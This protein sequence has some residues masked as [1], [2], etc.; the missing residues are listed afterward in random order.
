MELL[1]IRHAQTTSN[2][3][4]ALDTGHP[5]ADLTELGEQQVAELARTLAPVTL[6][7]VFVSPRLRTRRTAE[8]L[9][10]DRGLDPVVRDGLVEVSAGDWEMSTETE[11]AQAYNATVSSWVRG[12]LEAAIPGGEPGAA[13]LARFDAVVE[14]VLATGLARVAI[15]AHGAVLRL[16]AGAR[17]IG[18]ADLALH[19]PLG[20]TGLVRLTRVDDGWQPTFWDT[21]VVAGGSHDDGPGGDS[22]DGS[23][24]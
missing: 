14:E 11:R 21:E 4:G 8:P 9:L 2:V 22:P 6:D 23:S 20:N 12:D 1:L 18:A 17:G 5:G 10:R 19:R 24:S 13:V 16:W 7:A 3:A 15:V